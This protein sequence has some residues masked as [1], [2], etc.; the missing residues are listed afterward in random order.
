MVE[1]TKIQGLVLLLLSALCWGP[2]FLF[3]KLSI[4]D[5]PPI[6]LVFLRVAISSV[7]LYLICLYQKQSLLAWRHLWTQ[8][9]IMGITLNALP[10]LLISYS[11]EYISSSLAGILISLSLIATAILA[12]FFGTHEPLNRKKVL[13]VCAGVVGLCFIY[14]P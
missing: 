1:N 11:E 8:F 9:A 3:I 7:F 5:F 14:A 6:T 12:H 10:F 4:I 13:G 2:T